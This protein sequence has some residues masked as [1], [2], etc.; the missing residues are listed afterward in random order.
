LPET[1]T[2]FFVKLVTTINWIL[3]GL[4]GL[5]FLYTILNISRSGNDAAGR[6]MESGLIFIGF[7]LLAI[8]VG[9]NL[10]PRRG[11]RITAL[12]V[13]GLPLI[14]ILYNEASNYWTSYQQQKREADELT[15]TRR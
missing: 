5:L 9:L 6:G 4:Y 1:K 7:I 12:I 3:I 13:A 2:L 10:S 14:F 15:D 8:V 11:L